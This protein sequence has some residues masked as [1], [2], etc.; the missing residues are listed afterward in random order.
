ML[1]H[2]TN[3]E[4]DVAQAARSRYLAVMFAGES[5]NG[6]EYEGMFELEAIYWFVP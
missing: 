4:N 3:D 6:R 1:T 2:A 5:M